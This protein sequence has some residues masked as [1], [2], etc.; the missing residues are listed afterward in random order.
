MRIVKIAIYL[1]SILI[2]QN[3]LLGR[4][5]IFGGFPDLIL[6]SIIIFSVLTEIESATIFAFLAAFSAEL[7]GYGV[8]VSLLSK[9][10]MAVSANI[11]RDSFWDDKFSLSLCF[12]TIFTPI[13]L[14]LEAWILGFFF[15]HN[16]LLWGFMGT[17]ISSTIL[18][19]LMVFVLFPIIKR[20]SNNDQDK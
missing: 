11:L 6:T 18:N 19:S 16:F 13:T 4:I 2:I 5:N 10:L 12:V 15:G 9:V 1:I 20:L 8:F 14:C 17:I 7:L 3:V